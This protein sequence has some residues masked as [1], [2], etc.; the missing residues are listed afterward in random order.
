M[1]AQRIAGTFYKYA[2]SESSNRW[3]IVMVKAPVAGRVKTRL[4]AGVG[5]PLATAFYRN[6][7]NAVIGR[8][9]R[10]SRWSTVLSV[11]PDSAVGRA[12]WPKLTQIPQGRGDLGTRMENA[13]RALPPGPAVL[14]GSDIPGIE[15]KHIA[16]AFRRLGENDV[17]FG[18][19]EDGGYWLVGM[20]RRRPVLNP[21]KGVPW[22]SDRTLSENLRILGRY[23]TAM[24]DRL[25]D[26]DTS[27]EYHRVAASACRLV[28]PAK[29]ASSK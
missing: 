5:V 18:P 6:S 3:L 16:T 22:S 11:S 23:R 2:V 24:V 26:V 19:A 4:A 8:L 14:I 27:E 12:P 29:D 15:P 21:F 25:G 7:S 9:S 17:V 1:A 13:F 28:L 10:D 20:A